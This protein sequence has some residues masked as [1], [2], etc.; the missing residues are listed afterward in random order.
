MTE[1]D[2]KTGGV[3][4][5]LPIF[6]IE[7]DAFAAGM[8][9][10]ITGVVGIAELSETEIVLMMKRERVRISGK[11]LTV[12]IYERNTVEISGG[13]SMLERVAPVRRGGMDAK[14]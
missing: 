1:K 13:I 7:A 2:R 12:S 9:L 14:T 10:L 4:S 6:R 11:S 3:S 8:E 5:A